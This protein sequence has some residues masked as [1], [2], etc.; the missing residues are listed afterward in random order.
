MLNLQ[1]E[2]AKTLSINTEQAIYIET[3]KEE[4]AFLR[5]ANKNLSTALENASE[6]LQKYLTS[7]YQMK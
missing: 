3:L 5:A 2:L 1:K 6:A 4:V 7:N